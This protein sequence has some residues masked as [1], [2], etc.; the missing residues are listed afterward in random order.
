MSR[1]LKNHLPFRKLYN[2]MKSSFLILYIKKS[3]MWWLNDTHSKL[4]Q[5]CARR[6]PP[7][8]H[9][10]NSR[11]YV[12][13]AYTTE[14]MPKHVEMPKKSPTF[15][16]M[17]NSMKSNFLILYSDKSAI[18]WPKQTHSKLIQFCARRGPPGKQ[19]LNFRK[20]VS[21]AYTTEKYAKTCR[22]AEKITYLSENCIIA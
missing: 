14:S 12:S 3:A 5:L 10:L 4:I 6:G 16:K 17:H 8:K 19:F 15:Q 2:S 11:E 22:D 1:C 13:K 9:F 7:G 21:K 20:Y 18:W